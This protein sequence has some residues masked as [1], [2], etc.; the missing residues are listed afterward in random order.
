VEDSEKYKANK[1][2]NYLKIFLS[3]LIEI[4]NIYYNAQQSFSKSSSNYLKML[5]KYPKEII[6]KLFLKYNSEKNALNVA[7][8]TK[9]DIISVILEFTKYYKK[10]IINFFEF[11]NF[12]QE[13]IEKESTNYQ[14]ETISDKEGWIGSNKTYQ[15]SMKILEFIYQLSDRK[16]ITTNYIQYVPLFVSLYRVDFD[17]LNDDDQFKFWSL[18][19]DKYSELPILKN[20]I[21][22]IFSKFYF[23]K[24]FYQK[25]LSFKD[26]YKKLFNIENTKTKKNETLNDTYKKVDEYITNNKTTILP[27]TFNYMPTT[28]EYRAK[29]ESSLKNYVKGKL[30]QEP[31]NYDIYENTKIRNEQPKK[32]L[33]IKFQDITNTSYQKNINFYENLC[34]GLLVQKQYDLALEIA[35]NHV[36][37]Y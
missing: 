31:Q 17:N 30:K 29:L 32:D 37:F 35:D 2:P 20:Y 14:T 21:K 10:S 8:R 22:L 36:Y 24:T 11:N 33:G 5:T 28:N 23:I 26:L 4:G 25:N 3:Y 12:F 6:A 13:F 18:L 27:K 34:R 15:L 16:E 9:T 7:K 1:T 19:I